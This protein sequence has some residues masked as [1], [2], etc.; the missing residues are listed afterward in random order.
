M[1]GGARRPGTRLAAVPATGD[2]W[3][4]PSDSLHY[5]AAAHAA[6]R[7][8]AI[9][10]DGPSG[11]VSYGQLLARASALAAGLADQGAGRGDRVV[12]WCAS[13]AESIIAMQAVLLLGAAYVPMSDD[14][15][16]ALVARSAQ[17][18]DARLVCTSADRL[19]ALAEAGAVN[20][21]DSARLSMTGRTLREPAD[22]RP[23]DL[24]Y[25]LYTSGSTGNPKGVMLSHGNGRAFVDWAAAEVGLTER[26]RV[27]NHA[28]F[29]F[30]LSV[31]DIYAAFAAG[32][33]VVPVPHAWKSDPRKLTRFL[34]D[35]RISVWYSVPS[36]LM[37][38]MRFGGLTDSP[39]PQWLR[40]IL[41]AGEPF[42][43]GAV[44]RLA[45]W[46]DCVLYNLYGTTETNVCSYHRVTPADLASG[47]PLPIGRPCSGDRMWADPLPDG[48]TDGVGELYVDGPSV[49]L[50]YWGR[51]PHRGPFPMGDLV[52]ELPDGEFSYLGRADDMLK[53]R[54]NRIEPAEVEAAAN[55]YPAVVASALVSTGTGIDTRLVL[56]VETDGA[57]EVAVLA[58][59]RYLSGRLAGYM[60]PDEV[61]FVPAIPRGARGKV[62]RKA[63]KV[64]ASEPER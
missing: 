35:E 13:P 7:P 5:L 22:V 49:F 43:V 46:C 14:F 30:T 17:D 58:L 38:M 55:A 42:P 47:D 41:F 6:A 60:M 16:P 31:F 63:A 53:I 11:Q 57:G 37:L 3:L 2:G 56:V 54:G 39:P 20:A 34:H 24:A 51:S 32:A 12:V 1:T 18:C 33:T 48:G 44:R 28:T 29:N 26:D 8:D 64:I 15:P 52:R 50:G 27:G 10:I 59:R 62:D 61:I 25:I 36:A 23:A 9:A 4:P 19:A 40:T 21:V 45:G